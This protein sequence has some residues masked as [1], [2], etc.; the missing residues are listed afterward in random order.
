L[1]RLPTRLQR[2]HHADRRATSRHRSLQRP[3]TAK[4]AVNR[5][6]SH[7]RHGHYRSGGPNESSKADDRDSCTEK[8]IDSAL[9]RHL[10]SWQRTLHKPPH[11]LATT[12]TTHA[13]QAEG[14]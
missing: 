10:F 7:Q 9:L 6:D 1:R 8:Q 13:V 12:R 11:I 5:D 4:R 14:R 3:F 2:S